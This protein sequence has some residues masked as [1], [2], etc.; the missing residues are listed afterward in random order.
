[1]R[2]EDDFARSACTDDDCAIADLTKRTAFRVTDADKKRRCIVVDGSRVAVSDFKERVTD[3]HHATADEVFKI[4]LC[5]DFELAQCFTDKGREAFGD[6]LRAV[7]G[8]AGTARTISECGDD[9]GAAIPA[10]ACADRESILT[11]YRHGLVCG[12]LAYRLCPGERA[13]AHTSAK[14]ST[15]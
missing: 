13:H 4:G 3:Q 14:F 8:V 5:F 1:M 15:F 12:A 6:V 2:P 7:F 11:G 9:P 10:R